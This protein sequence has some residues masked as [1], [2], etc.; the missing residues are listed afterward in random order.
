MPLAIVIVGQGRSEFR[1]MFCALR[2]PDAIGPVIASNASSLAESVCALRRTASWRAKANGL[3]PGVDAIQ[4]STV[5]GSSVSSSG[6]RNA[7]AA[8][9][10]EP[11]WMT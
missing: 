8:P 11:S 6:S 10:A 3:S 2:L 9:N 4:P 7:Q 5:A 1:R